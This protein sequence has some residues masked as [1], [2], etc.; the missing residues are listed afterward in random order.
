M[1]KRLGL[2]VFFVI[3]FGHIA[4]SA[5]YYVND[6]YTVSD[7]YSLSTGNNSFNGT[8]PN[9]PK[10]SLT[11][12]LSTYIGVFST[13]DTIF[14]DHGDYS[15]VNLSSPPN[16]VVI[17]GAG[18]GNTIFTNG[19]PD[20]YFMYINDDN[21]VLSSMTVI[22]YN[23]QTSG[24]GQALGVVSLTTGVEINYV[25]IFKSS[26]TSSGSDFPIIV[27]SGA[28]VS[29][30][31]GGSVCNIWDAGGG[32]Q[33]K[34][35]ATTVNID[36]YIFKNNY[37][38]FASPA[39][40][41]LWVQNGTVTVMNSLF[42]ENEANGS[43]S[44]GA[45]LYIQGGDVEVIDCLF[46]K[47][48]SY[49]TYNGIGGT[50]Y[51]N[52]GQL[53]LSRSIISN[54]LQLSS[55]GT[56]YG[57]GIGIEGGTIAIDSCIFSN[58]QG[59]SIRGKDLYNDGGNVTLTDTWL[60]S[61]GDQYGSKS[62]T[63]VFNY[64]GSPVPGSYNIN[65]TN[66]FAA[67]RYTT[68]LT[69]KIPEYTG[70]CNSTINIL[71]VELISFTSNCQDQNSIIFNWATS[72]EV[73]NDYFILSSSENGID[74]NIEDEIKG[75]GTTQ[76]IEH[77]QYILENVRN[78]E[79]K[80]SQRDFDGVVEDLKIVHATLD[81]SSPIPFSAF[82]NGNSSTIEIDYHTGESELINIQLIN[83]MGK[84]IMQKECIFDRI[85]FHESIE[86]D[87]TV[88]TGIYYLTLA[89]KS[90]ALSTKVYIQR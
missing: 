54:H 64:C 60:T 40:A 12:L 88:V 11:N 25:Q 50:I 70:D 1:L 29:F 57:A 89:G 33:V 10:L 41:G 15:D 82:F 69:G 26:T 3:G 47:N 73:N 63:T 79:F 84:V 7:V 13:G 83:A 81:C 55:G 31:G 28:E 67:Q 77:Y 44:V 14:I 34:G 42:D 51:I 39:S 45:A 16:G 36:N 4:I 72:S 30:N 78:T 23:N 80:L 53:R 22:N 87:N 27:D 18:M 62:G 75:S 86:L 52:G 43:A 58:N 90:D 24:N 20:C 46:D 32:I 56:S 19:C 38:L 74:W 2:G 8:H 66:N 9:T 71:P 21:T 5:N 61:S 17:Q 68:D 59:S 6:N 76:N 48:E 35:A 65:V 37:Q 85:K 49:R